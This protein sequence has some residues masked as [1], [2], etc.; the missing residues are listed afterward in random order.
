MKT[1]EEERALI[2][3][4]PYHDAQNLASPSFLARFFVLADLGYWLSRLYN[5]ST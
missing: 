5:R 3:E 2:L 4:N 1:P